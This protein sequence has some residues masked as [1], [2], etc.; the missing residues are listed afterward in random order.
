V[1]HATISRIEN[2]GTS[3]RDT[4]RRLAR[5][6]KVTPEELM[7]EEVANK[8]STLLEEDA[9][10]REDLYLNR[11][12]LGN[13]AFDAD[14]EEGIVEAYLRIVDSEGRTDEVIRRIIQWAL[15]TGK[16]RGKELA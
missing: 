10:E 7:S 5:A 13:E 9:R 14:Y 12:A 4:I 8:P 15:N 16:S 3:T 6:L 11:L 2:G 1:H